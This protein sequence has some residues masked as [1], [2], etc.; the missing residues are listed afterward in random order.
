MAGPCDRVAASSL[1]GKQRE[2]RGPAAAAGAFQGNRE[3][4]DVLSPEGP[5]EG[6]LRWGRWGGGRWFLG[7]GVTLGWEA[8]GWP[9]YRGTSFSPAGWPGVRWGGL[10]LRGGPVPGAGW[11]VA[12]VV[13]VSAAGA[14]ATRLSVEGNMCS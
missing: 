13:Q 11:S 8:P 3:T 4:V 5:Q 9:A 10:W 14:G 12:C 7:R 2:V 6:L 1:D